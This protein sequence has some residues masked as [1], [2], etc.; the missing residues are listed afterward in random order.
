MC[1]KGWRRIFRVMAVGITLLCGNMLGAYQEGAAAGKS[2]TPFL[3]QA[4]ET[5]EEKQYL[6]VRTDGP[7]LLSD[8]SAK[9]VLV[10]FINVL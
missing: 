2:I 1:S 6:G 3:L 10:E 4:P 9:F 5:S 8:I 7:F